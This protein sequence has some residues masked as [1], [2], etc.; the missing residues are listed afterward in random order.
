MALPC[1]SIGTASGSPRALFTAAGAFDANRAILFSNVVAGGGAGAVGGFSALD[2]VGGAGSVAPS[3]AAL[4]LTDAETRITQAI[5]QL[6]SIAGALGNYSQVLQ[7]RAVFQ[8][9]YAT[10]LQDGARKLTLADLNQASARSQASSLRIE[11][12][13][14]SAALQGQI[15]ASI[16]QILHAPGAAPH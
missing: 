2:T 8:Q 11:L 6:Q 15:R 5:S 1:R 4:I 16:L 9:S 13:L 12:G 7:T 3:A 14:Q 10:Q